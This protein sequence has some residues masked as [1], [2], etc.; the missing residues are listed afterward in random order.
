[1]Y[2]TIN[3]IYEKRASHSE[4]ART[5]RKKHEGLAVFVEENKEELLSKTTV[6]QAVKPDTNK[7]FSEALAK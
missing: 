7:S 4:R 1:M 5:D 6:K 3:G 2:T